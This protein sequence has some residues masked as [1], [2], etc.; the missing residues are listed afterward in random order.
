MKH[1]VKVTV[2]DTL[3]YEDLQRE[4]CQNPCSGKCPVYNKG[5]VFVFYREDGKDS[6]WQCGLNTLVSTNGNP[7]EVAGGSAK[8]FC[9]EAWDAISRYIY[10]GLQGG[11]IMKARDQSFLK[12]KGSTCRNRNQSYVATKSWAMHR[13]FVGSKK[14]Y[15]LVA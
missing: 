14:T 12:L 4:Y 13:L 7:A 6:F 10:T 1:R 8:P 3:L 11:S 2:L 5:D 9:S 15:N